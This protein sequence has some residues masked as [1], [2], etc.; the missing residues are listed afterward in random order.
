MRSDLLSGG[1]QGPGGA[2]DSIWAGDS[3]RQASR[4]LV[5]DVI[6]MTSRWKKEFA[7]WE[8]VNIFDALSQL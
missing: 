3:L 8:I 4:V 7:I 6:A 2:S 1:F 5:S